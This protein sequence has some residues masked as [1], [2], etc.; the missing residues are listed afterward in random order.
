MPFLVF[1]MAQLFIESSLPTYKLACVAFNQILSYF[2]FIADLKQIIQERK[3][4]V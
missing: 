1:G 2:Y 3:P 4:L